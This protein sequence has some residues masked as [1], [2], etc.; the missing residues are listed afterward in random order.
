M[1]S[2]SFRRHL[3]A[4]IA[5]A[6]VLTLVAGAAF[7]QSIGELSSEISSLQGQMG[8]AESSESTANDVIS[9]LDRAEG[10]FAKLASGGK[11]DKSALIPLYRELESMLNR[12]VTVYAKKKDDCITTIDNG[13]QCDYDQPEQLSLRAAYP[14]SW[15][16]FQA[17]TTLFDDNAEESKKL[18]NQAIDGFTASTLAM[19]DPNLVRENT[20]GRAYCE[21]ELGKFD[22]ADY[23]RAIADFK[24]I[25]DDGTGTQQYKASEQGLSTTY[26][27]MGKPDE[28][29][30][31]GGG[32]TNT[33]GG[34]MLQLQTLFAAEK[35]TSDAGKKA[36]LHRQIIDVMKTKENDKTGWAIDIAAGSKY[37]GNAV[38]EFGNSSDPFEK[39][40]LANIL[41]NRKDENGAAKYYAEA[42][43]SGKYPKGYKFAADIYLRQKRYDEVES[44]LSRI[45]AGGGGDAQWAEYMKFSL[46]H[47]RWEQGGSK[48]KALEDQWVKDAQD[49]LQ[50]YPKGEHSAEPRFRLAERLQ[51]Q[52]NYVEAAKMYADITGESE[53]SYTAKFN[54]AECNYLAL[55]NA[56]NNKDKNA[57]KVDTDALR[58]AAIDGLV[59]T[60][61]MEPEVERNTP[62]AS[63]KFV[64]DTRGRA[65]YMLAGLLE[66][67]PTI[68]YA[69][70]GPLLKDF[71]TSYPGMNDRFQDVE[72]WRI[73]ALDAQG[74]YAEVERDVRSLVEKNK[75]NMAQS[76]FI[77]GLGLDFWKQAQMAQNIDQKR[78][79]ENAKLTAIAYS[80]FSDMV[81]A[82]KI[83]VKNLT[84][85]LSILGQADIA[86][87][88]VGKAE[89]IF[90]QVVKADPAS[91][92]ANAGLA[93]IAQAKKD[94]KTAV[95]MW[96][97]VESTAAE[98]DNLW[99]EA[100]YQLAVVYH[101]QG[102]TAESCNKLAATRAEHPSLGT[103]VMKAQWDTLQRKLCLD[104]KE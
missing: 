3:T 89:T 10:D 99:Y 79:L 70:I 19:P 46:V 6:A 27:K 57:P 33:G 66:Q 62:P 58:K 40:L 71:E 12:M 76:D 90:N 64:H 59:A 36:A 8:S 13:G 37:G 63:R 65:I 102:N 103:P 18:L 91:P 26:M 54:G 98:S 100:K 87:G 92:D 23:D 2:L 81:A 24:K 11:A 42:G 101:E 7:A 56:G 21:R 9:R 17:A 22:H 88:D 55:V 68:D 75:N 41:L 15:L 4:L 44:L 50:K 38:E 80:Y 84:G 48:D 104:H 1:K 96:T 51:H 31:Y 93:R 73:T 74:N 69:Q 94:W 39:W 28:A 60:V 16:R 97:N 61:K 78:Y 34:Q 14:L 29:L 82:G 25:M 83:P 47:S 32:A 77:K 5:A 53:F 67:Q 52:G 30:K 45:A 72:E 86:L 85:T 35:A 49:Y 43:A 20:L 95:T